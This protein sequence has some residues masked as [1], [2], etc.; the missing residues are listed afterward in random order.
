MDRA[1]E[2]EPAVQRLL[3]ESDRR[4]AARMG[5]EAE[6]P[7]VAGVRNHQ[8]GEREALAQPAAR[9]APAAAPVATVD[10][11]TV[12]RGAPATGASFLAKLKERQTGAGEAAPPA[13]GPFAALG[14]RSRPADTGVAPA[15]AAPASAL[16]SA[17]AST[18]GAA[19]SES[20]LCHR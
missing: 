7:Q 16:A 5:G 19:D 1:R 6:A 3:L 11:P 17:L 10:D 8:D 14:K 13:A 18:T 20:L 12:S 15:A 2:F 9:P 4:R